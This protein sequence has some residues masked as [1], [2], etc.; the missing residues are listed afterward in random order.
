MR[1][2]RVRPLTS[3]RSSIV[4]TAPMDQRDSIVEMDDAQFSADIQHRFNSRYGDM[5]LISKRYAYPLVGAHASKFCAKRFALI[6]DAAVR[7]A[8]RNCAW[9]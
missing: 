2:A 1:S 4:V 5:K 7:I 8:S 6:G 9:L 3:R